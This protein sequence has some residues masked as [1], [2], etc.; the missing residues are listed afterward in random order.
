M[1]DLTAATGFQPRLGACPACDA[2]PLAQRLAE[3][4]EAALPQNLILSLP[5]AHCALCISQVETALLAHQ[6]VRSAR[7]NLTLRRAT[8]D[9]PGLQASDLIP[10]LARA[11]HVA[12]ELDPDALSSTAAA[13]TSGRMRKSEEPSL[14]FI[15]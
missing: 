15:P 1:A 9:A 14:V 6:G 3:R 7:V 12:H 10:V 2:A 4:A 13:V 8:I 5:D 11:G